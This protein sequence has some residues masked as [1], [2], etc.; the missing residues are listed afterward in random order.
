MDLSSLP[1]AKRVVVIG[2]IHGDIQ[3]LIKCLYAAKLINTKLQ[4]VAEPR[5]TVLVQLGDQVDSINRGS[6]ESWE[7]LPDLEVV[8]FMETVA[9]MAEAA[10]GR[11]VSVLGNHE[12]MNVLGDFTFVSQSSLEKSGGPAGRL[13]LFR[14]GSDLC[15]RTLSKRPL[16][17]RVG[18][19]LFC[20]A[21]LL[22][23]HLDIGS[24]S[25]ERINFLAK[26]FIM[27]N[28]T[29]YDRDL[30]MRL[31]DPTDGLCW[32]RF[33]HQAPEQIVEPVLKTVL[34]RTGT[35]ALVLGHTPH[36]RITSK[37]NGR[38][39]FADVG[40]SRSFGNNKWQVFE[41]WDDGVP[42]AE[43]NFAPLRILTIEENMTSSG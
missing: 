32:T 27:G 21:G 25:I 16:V 6:N 35:N 5:D 29:Q 39:W 19:L 36:M 31:V 14:P 12:I 37:N 40:I 1:A 2:D 15:V 43:N 4:W 42:K 9:K 33:Y 34:E 24:N 38:L 17:S 10:G 3:R 18:S 13:K 23:Q 22:P 8:R 7:K 28:S 20:H 41:I 30:F 11:V 26:S